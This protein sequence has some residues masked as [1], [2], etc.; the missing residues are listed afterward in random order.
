MGIESTANP[1]DMGIGQMLLSDGALLQQFIDD[2][3]HEAFAALM[4]R[5]GPYLLSVCRQL[6]HHSQ[7][8]EDVFQAC[9]LQL[10]RKGK[11]IHQHSSVA[12]WLQKVA[13][14][15]ACKLRHQQARQWLKEAT[16]AMNQTV[17]DPPDLSWREAC[18]IL[19]EE[20]AALPDDLRLPIV[21]CLFQGQTQEDAG[22]ELGLNPRTVKDR[23]RRGREILHERLLSRG[24]SLSVLATMLAGG[25]LELTVP[26]A[27]AEVTQRGAVAVLSKGTL[28]G[29]VSPSVIALTAPSLGIAG[30]MAIAA[31]VASIVLTVAVFLGMDRLPWPTAIEARPTSPQGQGPRGVK[32]SFRDKQFDAELFQRTGPN[33]DKYLQPEDEGLRITLPAE[34]GPGDPVGIKLRYPLRGD[35]EVEAVFDFLQVPRPNKGAGGVSL[36]LNLASPQRDGLWVGK[37]NDQLRGPLF[38]AGRRAWEA[39]NRVD[40]FINSTPAGTETG[41]VRVRA[42]RRASTISLFAGDGAGP[43]LAHLGTLELSAADCITVRLAADPIWRDDLAIDVRLINFA[44]TAEEIVGYDPK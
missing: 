13:V 30:W 26:A 14:R 20:I 4:K 6:T 39:E 29:A 35:F 2:H 38:N 32:R 23:L 18:Q 7:D 34:N 11:S 33:A 42:L 44:V 5:H 31:V 36:Y 21:R 10:L 28:A 25:T 19:Q 3:N 24:V 40:K 22:Q 16:K 27:L 15:L 41:L 17:A 12:G 1:N 37:I 8:A 9:F 43:D